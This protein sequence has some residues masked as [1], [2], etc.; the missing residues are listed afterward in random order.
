M[1]VVKTLIKVK[2]MRVLDQSRHKKSKRRRKYN[3]KVHQVKVKIHL[4]NISNHILNL[5]LVITVLNKLE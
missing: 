2:Y 4:T 3:L 5:V 1:K